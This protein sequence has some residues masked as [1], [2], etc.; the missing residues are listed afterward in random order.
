MATL[1]PID[2]EEM[3]RLERALG[4]CARLSYEVPMSPS[5]LDY[6]LRHIPANR[7]CEV[8]MVILG[9][10]GRLLV[11][12]KS[13]YPEGV[14]RIPTG[15][16]HPR[17][18][19]MDALLREAWEET[20]L[21]VDV[22]RLL[23]VLEY[24]FTDGQRV[25]PFATYLFLLRFKSGEPSVQDEMERITEFREVDARD[26]TSLAISL[27]GLA[28]DWDDWGR[29]RALAHRAVAELLKGTT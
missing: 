9:P 3:A 14:F 5:S 19:V 11:H 25:L 20:G 26:L 23:A 7:R 15:G 13:F 17:E 2:P 1:A 10:N 12:T 29:F 28:K 24:R 16:V 4:P 27:E 22:E 21:E 8:G 18:R 6:W